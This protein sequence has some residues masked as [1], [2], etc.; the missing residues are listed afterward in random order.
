M[1][2]VVRNWQVIWGEHKFDCAIG[3]GGISANK[4]EGD[5]CTPIG[6]F[7][8]RKIYYRPDKLSLPGV[9][10]PVKAI[11]GD[12]GWCDDPKD[13]HYNSLVKL[14]HQASH[15]KLY[16]ADHL[17]DLVVVVGHNDDP[18]VPGKGS[19]VFIHVARENFSPTA[20]CIALKLENLLTIVGQADQSTYLHVEPAGPRSDLK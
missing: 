12:D 11:T 4:V 5:G 20:G 7:L 19:A 17:Y 16:R 3:R 6:R 14:P 10:L 9:S 8:W 18:P 15:E 2:L 13:T 1:D